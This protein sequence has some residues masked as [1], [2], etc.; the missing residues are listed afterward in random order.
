MTAFQAFL[1]GALVGELVTFVGLFRLCFKRGGTWD[2]AYELG[3]KHGR[4]LR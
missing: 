4:E 3:L 1:V 2:T